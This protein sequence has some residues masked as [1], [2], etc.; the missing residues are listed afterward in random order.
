VDRPAVAGD[1]ELLV[2]ITFLHARPPWEDRPVPGQVDIVM[3]GKPVGKARPRFGAG[4]HVYTPTPTKLA[5]A[6]LIDAW[7]QVG[8]PRL[9]GA[10]HLG[11]SLVV[12]RPKGHFRKDGTL[13]A[14]GLAKPHPTGKK[15]DADNAA[16][17]IMDAMNGRLYRDDVDVIELTVVRYWSD[18]GWERTII[19]AW[20]L[21]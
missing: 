19:R 21:P 7:Q 8:S 1:L 20:A 16:K 12:A 15:P 2:S 17:L 10:I 11:I 5:E 9:D 13:S 4:G 14:A 3:E 18:D 6:R